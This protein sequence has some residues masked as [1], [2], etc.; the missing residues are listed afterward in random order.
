MIINLAYG[1][2]GHTIELPDN[3]DVDI[4]EPRWVNSVKDQSFSVTEA[5]KNPYNSKPLKDIVRKSD[6]VAILFSDITRATPYHIILPALLNELKNIPQ[7]NIS[8]YC[9]NRTHR[10]VTDQELI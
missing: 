10:L 7:E 2:T 8:F 3:Y 4:L 6:K 1:K 5:L 9:A